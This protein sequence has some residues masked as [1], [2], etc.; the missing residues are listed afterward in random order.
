M[1]YSPDESIMN[2]PRYSDI[3]KAHSNLV[4][5]AHRTPILSS[6]RIDVITGGKLPMGMVRPAVDE[7]PP[8]SVTVTMAW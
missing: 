6:A 1:T 7:A 8:G 5:F 3:V 4:Q 2:I